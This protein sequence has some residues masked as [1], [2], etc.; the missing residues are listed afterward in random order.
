MKRL[1]LTSQVQFVAQDIGRKVESKYKQNSVFINTA[2][3]D[4]IHSNLEWHYLNKSSLEKEGFDF[5][6]YDISGKSPATINKDLSSY[7]SMYVE[8]GNSFYLLQ[9]SQKSGFIQLVRDRVNQGMI[10]IGTSAGS[11]IAG[12]SIE[13]V[14]QDSRA[15]LAPDLVGTEGYQLVDF[16]VMPHWGQ[17]KRRE[18]FNTY[19]LNHIYNE[20][21]GYLFLSDSQYVEVIDDHFKIVDIRVTKE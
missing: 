21:F 20:E 14:R 8:G 9:E 13:P 16:V 6:V 2:I 10:Y 7:D 12:P 18:L 19:R 11:V 17:P 4:K 3:K 5:D 15:I 1:F